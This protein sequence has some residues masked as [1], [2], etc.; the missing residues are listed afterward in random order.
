MRVLMPC[1]NERFDLGVELL[2][3][4]KIREPPACARE[5]AEPRLD[6][7]HPGA[8]HRRDMQDKAAVL[9]SPRADFLAVGRTDM[10]AH[11]VKRLDVWGDVGVQLCKKG[12]ERLRTFAGVTWPKNRTRA[13]IKCR[14]Y[15]EGPTARV[16]M[17][18]AV[19]DIPWLGGPRGMQPGTGWPRRLLGD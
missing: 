9:G 2:L 17:L 6:L 5:A 16:C 12:D 15:I 19:G 7:V 13:G 18:M 3:R 11:E 14:Q 8:V 4:V 10:I 1:T